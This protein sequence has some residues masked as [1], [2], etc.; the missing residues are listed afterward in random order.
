MKEL[1]EQGVGVIV[2]GTVTGVGMLVRMILF[3][4]YARLGKA[5]KQ[6]EKTSN[7]TISYIRE[8]LN[9]RTKNNRGIKNATV[10]TECRLAECK[11]CGIRIGILECMM[12]QSLLIVPL[13]GVLIA[14]AGVIL[15]CMGLTILMSLFVCSVAVLALLLMDLFTGM[16][17]KHKRI[18][19]TIRD[20]VEN[21]WALQTDGKENEAEPSRKDRKTLRKERKEEK[22][23]EKN[24]RS[25]DKSKRVTAKKNGKAQEEKR[26]LTEE[27]LRERRQLEARSFAQQRKKE[28]ERECQAGQV[29][30][31]AAV[32]ECRVQQ[33]QEEAAVTECV[34][35]LCMEQREQKQEEALVSKEPEIKMQ[36]FSYEDLLSEV[37]A[38]YLA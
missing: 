38:E 14:F 4:Y 1:L 8:E 12:Q 32:T 21:C 23:I 20:Y 18:R 17:E 2:I 26:R 27:L 25:A 6:F 9:R 30:E 11:V 10:Y 16:R 36:E 29:Q 37:L 28:Q 5:C 19:L 7:R 15:E 31:E 24:N 35:P 3:G 13:S 34:E 22:K 33:V